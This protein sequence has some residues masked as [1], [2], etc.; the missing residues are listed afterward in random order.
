MAGWRALFRSR[1]SVL[2]VVSLLLNG[3]LVGMLLTDQVRSQKPPGS[4][5][6]RV[7]G[8]EIRRMAER[9]PEEGVERI[10]AEL[11]TSAPAA[12]QRLERLRRMRAEI[13][14]LAA[15]PQPDRGAIDARLAELRAEVS[16]MQADVQKATF[17]ALLKLPPE[18]RSGLAEERQGS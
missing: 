9:L 6:S 1:R 3:F 16:A 13:N 15:A 12:H 14:A 8:F 2:L 4:S 7:V 18:M 11:Q 10:R 17:D 5:A